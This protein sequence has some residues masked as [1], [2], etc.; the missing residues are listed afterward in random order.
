MLRCPSIA[1]NIRFSV[2]SIGHKKIP[3]GVVL[4]YQ[5]ARC[6]GR[7]PLL[8]TDGFCHANR[9]IAHPRVSCK[10]HRLEGQGLSSR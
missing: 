6:P 1:S 9:H 4:V 10:T 7:Q 2:A 8:N 5:D 3:V